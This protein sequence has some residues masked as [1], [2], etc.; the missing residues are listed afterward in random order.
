[1][2]LTAEFL[3]ERMSDEERERAKIVES[4]LPILAEAAVSVDTEGE[5]YTDH[6]KTLG[7]AGLLG[8]V[9]PIKFNIT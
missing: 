6:I 1:M 4:V 2:T 7:D 3:V 9:V 5:F 8:L